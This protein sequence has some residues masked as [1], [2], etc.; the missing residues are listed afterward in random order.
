MHSKKKHADIYNG[1]QRYFVPSFKISLNI[2]L[3]NTQY[4]HLSTIC[5]FVFFSNFPQRLASVVQ[6]VQNGAK[7]IDTVACLYVIVL[8]PLWSI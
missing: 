5:L 7:K 4:H 6:V 8:L 2:Q 3:I 1:V